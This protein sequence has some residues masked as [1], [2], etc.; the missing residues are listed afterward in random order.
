[1]HSYFVYWSG[2]KHASDNTLESL[3]SFGIKRE[4]DAERKLC[5]LVLWEPAQSCNT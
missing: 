4:S 1:M 3:S 2:V 5:C